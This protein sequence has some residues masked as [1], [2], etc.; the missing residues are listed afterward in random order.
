MRWCAIIKCNVCPHGCSLDEGRTGLCG[1]RKNE[2]GRNVSTNY[3]RL[4]SIALDPI[5]KKPL[6]CFY[7]GSYILSV[8]SF[9]CNMSC[10]FCQNHEISSVRRD[11]DRLEDCRLLMPEELAALAKRYITK[12]NIGLA[13]TYNEP[14]IGY[15]YVIDASREVKKLGLK[16]AAVTNGLVTGETG[17]LIIPWIDAY[18]ID[19]KG[20]T[21]KWYKTLG[22]D[23]ETVKDFIIQASKAAH[24]E[25]TTL[26]VP[27]ENDSEDE[28][29]ELAAWLK[30]VNK[31]IPLHL[32]RF[33]PRY[34]MK[35]KQATDVKHMYK[36][37]DIALKHLDTV[38][39][40]NVT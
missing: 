21:G 4:S 14:L 35:D 6:M 25:V 27:G 11:I 38:F 10:P 23:L 9:G 26:L 17:E 33:F 18:N 7:P 20:F 31:A 19:L 1:V 30:T 36:L 29:Y 37:R 39:L 12:G 32:T 13:F 2:G 24:V 22:G 16:T 34:K 5:E 28:I 3:G 8:G 40:G 15:E